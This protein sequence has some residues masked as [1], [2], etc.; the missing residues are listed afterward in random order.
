MLLVGCSSWWSCDH[1]FSFVMLVVPGHGISPGCKQ[2]LLLLGP[3]VVWLCDPHGVASCISPS[4]CPFPA[5]APCGRYSKGMRATAGGYPV[6]LLTGTLL[7]QVL[8][9]FATAVGLMY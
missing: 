1:F 2:L 7:C 9:A 4:C 5:V 3:V 6:A 8:V